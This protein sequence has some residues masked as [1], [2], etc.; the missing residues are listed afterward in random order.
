MEVDN[1]VTRSDL[2][3]ILFW[4]EYKIRFC[5]ALADRNHSK[6]RI[7][8]FALY[9]SILLNCGLLLGA[10]LNPWLLIPGIIGSF[11]IIGIVVW[12]A[13][14]TYANDAALF[15]TATAFLQILLMNA[16]RLLRDS[17]KSDEQVKVELE[18]IRTCMNLV[19]RATPVVIDDKLDH[20]VY[21]EATMITKNLY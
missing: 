4:L 2:R 7:F 11:L 21:D 15:N 20:R 13:S 19:I 10:T 6:C 1:S 18:N 12:D 14:S 9:I 16:G 3:S 8:R 5:S 17:L